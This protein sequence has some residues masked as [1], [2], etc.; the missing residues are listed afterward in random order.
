MARDYP[1]ARSTPNHRRKSISFQRSR[2][3][4]ILYAQCSSTSFQS[5]LARVEK[6][7]PLLFA[8]ALFCN[9]HSFPIPEPILVTMNAR[10]MDSTLLGPVCVSSPHT[11]LWSQIY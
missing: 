10:N 5:S 4:N 7:R 6:S 1:A 8:S 3:K 11:S 9:P 2:L